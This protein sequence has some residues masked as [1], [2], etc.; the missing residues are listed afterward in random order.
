LNPHENRTIPPLKHHWVWSLARDFP[1]LQFTL[2]GGITGAHEARSALDQRH[3][4]A[5][6]HGIMIGRAAYYYPWQTLSN[7]DSIVYGEENPAVNRRQVLKEYAEYA[8]QMCGRWGVADDGHKNPSVRT[9]MKP[10]LN[11]FAAEPRN[12]NWKRLV[13]DVIKRA[14]SVSELLDK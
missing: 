6:L 9:L 8:D 12:K 11:L 2:N 7:V 5:G 1:D 14:D 4:G 3:E 10:I 13:D